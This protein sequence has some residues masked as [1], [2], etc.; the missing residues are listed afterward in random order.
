MSG[1]SRVKSIEYCARNVS[2]ARSDRRRS[3]FCMSARA[4][5][6]SS[7]GSLNFAHQR[8]EAGSELVAGAPGRGENR[9]EISSCGRS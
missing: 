4:T 3:M 1:K 8:S 2:S 9:S 7:T 5:R 6:S